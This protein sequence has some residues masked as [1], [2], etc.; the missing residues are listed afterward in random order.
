M[1]VTDRGRV[2]KKIAIVG[3]GSWS[4]DM[5]MP[6]FRRLRDAGRADYA[7]VC[8]LDLV[9]VGGGVM[10]ISIALNAARRTDPL[11]DPVILN[12]IRSCSRPTG[13]C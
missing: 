5:H 9:V 11:T 6:A 3:A 7:A 2:K 4:R 1:R 10:G 8:D 12:S 13:W